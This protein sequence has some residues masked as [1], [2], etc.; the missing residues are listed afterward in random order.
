MD[1]DCTTHKNSYITAYWTTYKEADFATYRT[2]FW[3][4]HNEADFAT[5]RT[6]LWTTY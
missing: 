4:T 2:T 6:A 5:Y 1:A 3:T